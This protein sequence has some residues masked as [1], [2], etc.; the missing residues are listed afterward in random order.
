MGMPY[1]DSESTIA[2]MVAM[3]GC[4]AHLVADI[5]PFRGAR[6]PGP[7]VLVG[8]ARSWLVAVSSGTSG[9]QIEGERFEVRIGDRAVPRRRITTVAHTKRLGSNAF[10]GAPSRSR[11]RP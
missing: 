11:L 9:R 4:Q 8:D 3:T 5:E 1:G 10:V 2:F 6:N 7:A